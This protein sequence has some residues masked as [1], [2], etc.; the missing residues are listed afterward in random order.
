MLSLI[1]GRA[2]C[3]NIEEIYNRIEKTD[4][5][6]LLIVPEQFSLISERGLLDKFKDG[7]SLKTEV[8]S[9]K[10]LPQFIFRHLGGS[11][12]TYIDDSGEKL[13]LAQVLAD[14]RLNLSYFKTLSSKPDFL[15]IC[16]STLR[17]FDSYGITADDLQRL[18]DIYHKKSPKLADKYFDLSLIVEAY[19]GKFQHEYSTVQFE[20]DI[21]CEKLQ[22]DNIFEQYHIFIAHFKGFTPKEYKLFDFLLAAK[23]LTINLL[24]DERDSEG[25]FSYAA[26]TKKKLS[27]LAMSKKVEVSEFF[28]CKG[29]SLVDSDFAFIEQN[30]FSNSL[31]TDFVAKDA[32]GQ[33]KIV[34]A[35]NSYEEVS[36]VANEIAELVNTKKVRFKDIAIVSRATDASPTLSALLDKHK[37]SHQMDCPDY[38]LKYP[39]LKFVFAAFYVVDQ[40]YSSESV[41]TYMKSFIFVE[42]AIS[43]QSLCEYA[44]K[45]NVRGSAWKEEFCRNPNGYNM[46]FNQSSLDALAQINKFRE[47]IIE[48]LIEFERTIKN[49]GSANIAS[50]IMTLLDK[51]NSLLALTTLIKDSRDNNDEARAQK[52]EQIW[53]SFV[54]A[55]DQTVLI[56]DD[57]ITYSSYAELLKKSLSNAV[58]ST[59]PTTIDAVQVTSVDR[60]LP[61]MYDYVFLINFNEKSFPKPLD[62]GTLIT[63]AE[64][65]FFNEQNLSLSPSVFEKVFE[66]R[67]YAYIAMTSAKKQLTI[68]YSQSEEGGETLR[69]SHFLLFLKKLFTNLEEVEIEGGSFEQIET[70]LN[71][72]RLFDNSSIARELFESRG[73]LSP[74]AVEQY[75]KCKFSFFCGRGLRLKSGEAYSFDAKEIGTFIH[76]VMEELFRKLKRDSDGAFD[77]TML[78][79]TA[80]IELVES[81]IMSY[82][83]HNFSDFQ[84]ES[85]R[86]KYLF[87]RLRAIIDNFVLSIIEEFSNSDFVPLDFELKIGRDIPEH[88]LSDGKI[89]V[90]GTVDRVDGFVKDGVHYLRILDYKTGKKAFS[91]ADVHAGLSIQTLMYLFAL[92]DQGNVRY[93][94]AI[95]PAGVLYSPVRLDLVQAGTQRLM[96]DEQKRTQKQKSV[97]KS[98]LLIGDDDILF[99]MDKSKMFSQLPITVK[100]SDNG[101]LTVDEKKSNIASISQFIDL[102]KFIEQHIEQVYENIMAGDVSI[103]PRLDSEQYAPCGFC[104]FLTI[105]RN[106]EEPKPI[107]SMKASDFWENI[108]ADLEGGDN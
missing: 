61:N 66:E 35:E 20:I 3:N 82:I 78:E 33:L 10:R 102:K 76:F 53:N 6:C 31:D 95:A 68:S 83:E 85:E 45:W 11:Q 92:L 25:I 106:K 42:D 99:K 51:T 77:V 57:K 9:F 26:K 62:S 64:K 56:L 96:S 58:A 17:E 69:P 23:N 18:S 4:G 65:I 21:A 54:T 29:D 89:V 101:N 86:F 67:Y 32:I 98:G 40:N 37:I 47:Y 2:D 75:Q 105:C 5:K 91:Y 39:L 107:A 108:K 41:I 59:V 73:A 52:L 8:L 46:E 43:M 84:L 28:N 38:V 14:L 88:K 100:P 15:D 30:L 48:P 12:R 74:S 90:K 16:L 27:E 50:S 1:Y 24:Y 87:L 13:V 79:E 71:K 22:S 70:Q 104:E 94:D 93:G 60:V 19:K 81:C 44:R 72:S 80:G 55:I 7:A 97:E 63:E 34:K 49:G 103:E 36:H